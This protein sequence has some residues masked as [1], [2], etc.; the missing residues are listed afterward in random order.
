MFHTIV[1][2]FL[3]VVVVSVTPNYTL[4]WFCCLVFTVFAWNKL[5]FLFDKLH[6]ILWHHA[7]SQTKNKFW[8]S[9][10]YYIECNITDCCLIY[11]SCQILLEFR[12]YHSIFLRG[13]ISIEQHWIQLVTIGNTIFELFFKDSLWIHNVIGVSNF[14]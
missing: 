8:I 7:Q 5:Y 3:F 10:N 11:T 9:H 4:N 2:L 13:N 12:I 14:W 1:K 6:K